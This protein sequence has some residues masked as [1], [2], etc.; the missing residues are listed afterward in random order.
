MEH[1]ED[2]LRQ[3][4]PRLRTGVIEQAEIDSRGSLC[5]ERHVRA[6]VPVGRD[7]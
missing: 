4:D 5:P 7:A 6:T 2:A 1:V 3:R